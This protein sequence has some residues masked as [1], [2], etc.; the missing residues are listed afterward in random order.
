MPGGQGKGVRASGV[1]PIG[2]RR[3]ARH[4]VITWPV[5]VLS[6]QSNQ[7]EAM[8]TAT[9][10]TIW[11]TAEAALRKVLLTN[12]EFSVITGL[13]G[14]IFGGLAAHGLGIDQMWLIQLLSAGLRNLDVGPLRPCG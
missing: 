14:L 2:R 13:I 6:C 9:T 7:A 1:K 12:T 10:S 4:S 8:T 11:S 5:I 3:P